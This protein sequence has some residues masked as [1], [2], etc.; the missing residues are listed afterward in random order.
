MPRIELDPIVPRVVAPNG[1]E[2][3]P[4]LRFMDA[5]C[6]VPPWASP[7]GSHR[8]LIFDLRSV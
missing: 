2:L 7:S 3:H 5:T 6:E 4:V 1:I 8:V